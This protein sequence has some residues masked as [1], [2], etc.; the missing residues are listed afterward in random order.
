[1]ICP[2]LDKVYERE[3]EDIEEDTII[4]PY[5]GEIIPEKKSGDRSRAVGRVLQY[6]SR[7]KAYW[8]MRI[9]SLQ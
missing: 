8:L 1:L 6:I 4:G 9:K 2:S 3:L 7:I 5:V